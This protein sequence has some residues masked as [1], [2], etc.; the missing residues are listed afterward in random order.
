MLQAPSS[1]SSDWMVSMADFTPGVA[2]A[3]R[4]MK[5]VYPPAAMGEAGAVVMENSEAL[6]PVSGVEVMVREP[7]PVLFIRTVTSVVLPMS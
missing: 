5:S 6:L 2:G 1:A 4:M 3:K 7:V